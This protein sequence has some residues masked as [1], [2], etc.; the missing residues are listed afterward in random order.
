[1]MNIGHAKG[2]K[3]VG[4]YQIRNADQTSLKILGDGEELGLNQIIQKFDY[5]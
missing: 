5:P 2:I 4:F 3:S 1:M